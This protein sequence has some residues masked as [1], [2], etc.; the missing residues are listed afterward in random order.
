MPLILPAVDLE[1]AGGMHLVRQ[2]GFPLAIG[3]LGNVQREDV[4]KRQVPDEVR[5]DVGRGI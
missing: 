1:K 5:K 4:Y 2:D 3:G